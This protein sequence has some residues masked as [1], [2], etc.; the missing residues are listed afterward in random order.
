VVAL[1]DRAGNP[2]STEKAFCPAT[3]QIAEV[4]HNPGTLDVNFL[5]NLRKTEKQE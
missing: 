5:Q 2:A 3:K 1:A 4:N